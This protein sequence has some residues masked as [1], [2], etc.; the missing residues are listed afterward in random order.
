MTQNGYFVAL[1]SSVF[2][3]LIEAAKISAPLTASATNHWSTAKLE[4]VKLTRRQPREHPLRAER[5]LRRGDNGVDVEGGQEEA[6]GG[7]LHGL[8]RARGRVP[9]LAVPVPP[10]GSRHRRG[11]AHFARGGTQ[12]LSIGRARGRVHRRDSR[13]VG[14]ENPLPLRAKQRLTYP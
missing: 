9:L 13:G 4:S 8:G 3:V 7:R 2:N 1:N 11:E 14:L 10:G 12:A 5:D 6:A